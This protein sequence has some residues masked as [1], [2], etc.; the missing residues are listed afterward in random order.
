MGHL[1]SALVS[2][3][4]GVNFGD[5]RQIC[6][7]GTVHQNVQLR[8]TGGVQC[9]QMVQCPHE[10]AYRQILSLQ[11]GQ[12]LGQP[13]CAARGARAVDEIHAGELVGPLDPVEPVVLGKVAQAKGLVF[14]ILVDA[15]RICLEHH[16]DGG[17]AG[18]RFGRYGADA[19]PW[20]G[21][22]VALQQ[23]GNHGFL[24]GCGRLSGGVADQQRPG[25]DPLL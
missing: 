25:H 21:L 17:H 10:A 6:S 11:A 16:V 2:L 18:L 15:M 12:F 20:Q 19:D 13:G 3:K 8:G 4:S 9:R 7:A 1:G 23:V 14:R 24:A 22:Q 5:E